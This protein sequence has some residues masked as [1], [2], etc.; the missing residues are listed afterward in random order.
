MDLSQ[1]ELLLRGPWDDIGWYYITP[2]SGPSQC[3]VPPRRPCTPQ[4]FLNEHIEIV[5]FGLLLMHL[6]R[7]KSLRLASMKRA[8]GLWRG[9]AGVPNIHVEATTTTVIPV[10]GSAPA[11]R[12]PADLYTWTGSDYRA[13]CGCSPVIPRFNASTDFVICAKMA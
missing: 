1:E 13:P 7:I 6:S 9:F 5:S 3:Y 11:Q 4:S 8:T 10:K 12:L 2:A